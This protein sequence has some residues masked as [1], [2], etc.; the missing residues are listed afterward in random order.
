MGKRAPTLAVL[1]TVTGLLAAP[2]TASAVPGCDGS[3]TYQRVTTS[4]TIARVVVSRNCR[5][6]L[7]LDVTYRSVPRTAAFLVVNP[8]ATCRTATG[9]QVRRASRSSAGGP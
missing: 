7:R 8:D 5:N 2:G 4:A 6:C 9:F 3:P 1:L